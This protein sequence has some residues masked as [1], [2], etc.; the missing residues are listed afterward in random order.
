MPWAKVTCITYEYKPQKR[1]LILPILCSC[2]VRK[3]LCAVPQARAQSPAQLKPCSPAIPQPSAGHVE[4]Q[5]PR[6]VSRNFHA[7]FRIP[8]PVQAR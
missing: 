1:N 2:Y 4:S 8:Q 7:G 6:A 3:R 5:P